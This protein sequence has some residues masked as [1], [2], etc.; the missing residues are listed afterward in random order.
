VLD[1]ATSA[2]DNESERVVQAALD[3][4]MT[5]PKRTTIVVARRLSTICNADKI[6]VVSG[7]R[8]VEVR[9]GMK[10]LSSG[11]QVGV[12]RPEQLRRRPARARRPCRCSAL[13]RTRFWHVVAD[14]QPIGSLVCRVV[15]ACVC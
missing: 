3:E 9:G 10:R 4:I 1:E 15:R 5:K 11:L 14:R 8:I 2:L 6:A 12:R 7:G 13:V